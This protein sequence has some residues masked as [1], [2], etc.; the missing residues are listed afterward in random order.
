MTDENAPAD[1]PPAPPPT[2]KPR[3]WVRVVGII[4]GGLLLLAILASGIMGTVF[5]SRIQAAVA[6]NTGAT[7]TV[8]YAWYLPPL[9]ISLHGVRLAK[10]G[11]DGREVELFTATRILL[12]L[13]ERPREGHPLLIRRLAIDGPYV[14]IARESLVSGA[15]GREVPA[16]RQKLISIGTPATN[17][18]KPS[19]PKRP[20]HPG[21]PLSTKF[22]ITD[23]EISNGQFTFEDRTGPRGAPIVMENINVRALPHRASFNAYDFILSADDPNCATIHSAGLV[24]VDSGILNIAQFKLRAKVAALITQAP[25]PR[26]LQA[27]THDRATDGALDIDGSAT[28][29]LRDPRAADFRATIL[30]NDA[31]TLLPRVNLAIQHANAKLT[32][33]STHAGGQRGASAVVEKLEMMAGKTLFHLDGATLAGDFQKGV[34]SIA[35][36]QGRLDVNG[37]VPA[38]DRMR[39]RGRWAFTATASGP[40]HAPPGVSPFASISHEIIAYPRDVSVQPR[41]YPL[42]VEHLNGGEVSLR[43]GVI[44]MRNLMASYGNDKL[45]LEQAHLTLDDPLQEQNVRDLARQIRVAAIVGTIQFHQPGPPYPAGLGKVIAQLRPSGDFTIGDGSWYAINRRLPGQ[46]FKP[47]DD[48]FFRVSKAGGAFALTTHKVPL[49]GIR[50]DATVSPMLVDLTHF[51]AHS[52]DGTVDLVGTVV[53]AA[54]VRYEGEVGLYDIDL[55]KLSQTFDLREGTHGPLRGKAYVKARLIGAGQPLGRSPAAALA[56][57]GEFEVI[58]GNFGTLTIV[59]AAADK[60][61]KPDDP[62]DGQAAGVFSI[63]NEV[64]TLKRCAVGNPTFGLEGSGTVGFDKRLNLH[65]AAAPL[66]D[67]R[68]ALR[69]SNIPIIDGIGSNIAGGIQQIFNGAQRVLLWD[70]HIEGTTAA[71]KVQ[72][73]PAP[74]ITQ[75]VAALFGQMLG[76]KKDRRLIDSVRDDQKDAGAT[77]PSRGVLSTKD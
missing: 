45:L 74:A 14:H 63:R 64:V 17:S 49:T 35:K 11:A 58:G 36:L 15:D 13:R 7:L 20:S 46:F 57:S 26:S 72:T 61:A 21:P 25:V 19:E 10:T 67:W 75:P 40:W 53:P 62:L 12:K 41:S 68:D 77:Q 8:G 38:L 55:A 9:G 5:R 1:P 4:V 34:W 27:S 18:S 23:F 73:T 76:G 60:V 29:P 50:G 54:P 52:I 70:I 59:R 32:V 22:Q 30:L 69:Q 6:Q 31:Q 16:P 2:R 33:A 28:V 43:G 24:N 51:H 48:Y 47:K 44:R 71:P 42:P 39:L 66:G 3:H 37:G 65:V 56:A